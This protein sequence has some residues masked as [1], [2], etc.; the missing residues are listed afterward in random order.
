MALKV[1][2]DPFL[3]SGRLSDCLPRA[4][5]HVCRGNPSTIEEAH[6]SSL[7]SAPIAEAETKGITVDKPAAMA[8]LWVEQDGEWVLSD[9]LPPLAA[10]HTVRLRRLTL[11]PA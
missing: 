9:D 10:G 7:G 2:T 11:T 6:A 3:L 5:A 4:T 8:T 1:N